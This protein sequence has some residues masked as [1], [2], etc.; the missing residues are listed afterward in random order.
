[1]A[2]NA[3]ATIEDD[4][5]DTNINN[6]FRI[7]IRQCFVSVQFFGLSGSSRLSQ[8]TLSQSE[9]SASAKIV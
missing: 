3:G 1:M 4:T 5:G 6:E 7:V 8:S 2:W 9:S